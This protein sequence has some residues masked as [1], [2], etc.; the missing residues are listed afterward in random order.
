MK[1]RDLAPLW[2]VRYRL[3]IIPRSPLVLPFFG[4][5]AILRG[6]FGITLRGLVCHDVSL[7]CRHCPL[8]DDCPYPETFEPAP[9][10]GGN[11]LSNFSDIPRP[12]VFDPPS[13]ERA[14][15]RAGEVVEFGLTVAGHASRLTPYFISAFKQLGDKGLGPRRARFD[16]AEVLALE[17]PYV[18]S[19][20]AKQT[21]TT[22]YDNTQP[23]IH[24]AAPR[25]CPEQLVMPDDSTRTRLTLR[26]AT[27]A[28]IRD[29]SRQVTTPAFGA[30]VRRLRDRASSL[31]SFF[32]DGPL[33][34][35]FKGISAL[36]DTVR[37]AENRSRVVT[38]NRRSSKTGQRH[39]IGGFVGEAVYE[40][41]A[42]GRLMPLIRLGEVMHVG[43]HAAFGNGRI[44]VL[45]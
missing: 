1:V 27:P 4:R 14:E 22:V 2:F 24:P 25:L 39:D 38:V 7:Q 42:I 19:G 29:D 41:E 31:A 3:R 10:A 15:F 33:D 26:F 23:V 43:K 5:G 8:L 44:E 40:G 28:E 18:Q 17:H 16:L 34:L 13:D 32:G 36:A 20:A 11:R 30:I 12:F 37:T 9:P 6:A 35:D 45:Q 21:V